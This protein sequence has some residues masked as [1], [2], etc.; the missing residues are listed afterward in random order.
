M[1]VLPLVGVDDARRDAVFR[2]TTGVEVFN[3]HEHGRGDTLHDFVEAH[4][5]GVPDEV[6]DGVGVLHAS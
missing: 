6:N 2:R 3:L 4:K 1:P 5:R